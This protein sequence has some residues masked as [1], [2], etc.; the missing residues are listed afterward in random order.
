MIKD[1]SSTEKSLAETLSRSPLTGYR[2]D[3]SIIISYQ[4]L[5]NIPSRIFSHNRRNE[6]E[7]K[8]ATESKNCH[9]RISSFLL[10]AERKTQEE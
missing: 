3:A 1:E 10:H 9:K 5:S 2:N 6:S 7:G 8:T 4:V